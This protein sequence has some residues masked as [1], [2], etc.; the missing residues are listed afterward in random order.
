MNGHRS[1]DFRF[2][3][4]ANQEDKSV[5][6]SSQK[7]HIKQLSLEVIEEEKVDPRDQMPGNNQKS[8]PANNSIIKIQPNHSVPMKNQ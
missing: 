2:D 6:P 1:D 4:D 3:V 5:A 7:P 8:S